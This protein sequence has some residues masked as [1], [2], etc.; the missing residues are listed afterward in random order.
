MR[1]DVDRLFV[2]LDTPIHE[3]VKCIDRSGRLS[4]ALLVD[5]NGRLLY[6]LTDGDIRRGI[7]AGVAMNAPAER[8]LSSKAKMPHYAPVTASVGTKPDALLALMREKAVRHVPLVDAEG[9]PTE[10]VILA[11]LLEPGARPLQAVVMAGGFGAR[12]R[13]LT[14]DVPKPMLPV[15]GKPVMEH[16]INRLEK[17]GVR[18]IHVM[19]HYKP[20]KIIEHFGDGR[21]FGV[22]LSYLDEEQPLGTAGALGTMPRPTE[23]V[24]VI[25]GDIL[26]D[27][28]FDAMLDYHR[29]TEAELTMAVRHYDIAVPYGVVECKGP[30]VQ[31]LSEKPKLSLFVNAGIYL[32]EPT[33]YQHIPVGER[34][35]M[36]DLIQRLLDMGHRVA[37]F[38]VV[39][40]WLDIGRHDDY[41][42]AQR[43]EGRNTETATNQGEVDHP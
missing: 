19:T 18:K 42:Q 34:L 6:T 22:E 35:D 21:K 38:P 14:E 43:Y 16:I 26:T 32:I 24:L 41:L 9:R 8:L 23:T 12:L 1:S 28:S 10:V 2:R 39:E 25:N 7:L 37:S 3:V 29:E 4:I 33:V 20:E 31:A 13:P 15:G 36:T 30:L 27:V 11:D 40:Y 17:G 5:D